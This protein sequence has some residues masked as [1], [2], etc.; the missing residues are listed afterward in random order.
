M[1]EKS[2]NR[3][4]DSAKKHY[5]SMF[6][7]PSL[8]TATLAVAVICI[9]GVSLSAYALFPQINSLLLGIAVF[10]L[11]TVTSLLVSQVF[12][13]SD[14][15][16]TTRRTLIVS[17][18]GWLVWLLFLVLGTGLGFVFG[19]LVWVKLALLGFAAVVTFRS[20]VVLATSSAAKWRQM[21]SIL[22]EPVFCI[23][24]LFAFLAMVSSTVTWQIVAFPV[25][26]VAAALVAVYVLLSSIDRLG[27]GTYGLPALSLF[28]AFLLNWVTDQNVP[29]E[30]HLEI[31]GQDADVEVSLLKFDAEK[32][33][34]AI[35]VP[36]VH[37]G[38]FKNIGSSLLPSLL[39]SG[40]QNEFGCD[41]CVPL[42]ILGHELDLASQTQNQKILKEVLSHAKQPTSS[43]FASPLVK[44]KKGYATVCCQIFGDAAFVTFS[45]APKTT[46]DLPQELG[47]TVTEE[48][49]RLGLKSAVLVNAHN[50]LTD[51]VDTDEHMDELRTAAFN[52]LQK[53]VSQPRQLFKV[54]AASVFPSEFSVKDG[55]GTGG[56][57]ATII[58]VESQ[59][60][61]YIVVDGNNMVPGLREKLLA[62]LAGLGFDE[63]EI[64]TT[65]THAVSARVTGK[66]GYHPV[67]EAMDL[68]LLVSY[69]GEAAKKA[70]ENMEPCSVDCVEFVVPNIRVIGE[71]RLQAVTTLVDRAI[72]KLKRI[73]VP[74]FGAEGLVLL[75]LLLLL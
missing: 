19:N 20:I 50:S 34:A 51:I 56:I 41:A 7:L 3:S 30:K 70:Q 57:T 26:A 2:L 5:S 69:I 29:L 37:P 15:I 21:L 63:G 66:Q 4:M 67:G 1:A 47:R 61:I 8:K 11:S 58:Q 14:P 6:F 49:K 42:G 18:A 45:L 24:A 35:I 32:P 75:L 64:F 74:I 28:K 38:P 31:M 60:T 62:A 73:V 23:A 43:K 68:H 53:A 39:K 22:L 13:K 25:A 71:E 59:K 72:A 10:A 33:K 52:C 55:M 27:Q 44:T 40:Y 9:A 54:G 46:E 65:D 16:F 36:L 17:L 12:L 48:A